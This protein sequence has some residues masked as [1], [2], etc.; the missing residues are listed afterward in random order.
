MLSTVIKHFKFSFQSN[1]FSIITSATRHP[2]KHPIDRRPAEK[3]NKLNCISL[4][5]LMFNIGVYCV[6][7]ISITSNSN[8]NG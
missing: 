5:F 1:T 6:M 7:E 3:K 4:L 8:S 2:I